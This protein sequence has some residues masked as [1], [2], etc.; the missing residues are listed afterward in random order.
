MATDLSDKSIQSI[1]D[2]EEAREL[3]AQWADEHEE[4]SADERKAH[5]W[6]L[7]VNDE[8]MST[9]DVEELERLCTEEEWDRLDVIMNGEA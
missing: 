8:W 5:L 9:E 6:D 3:D 7:M 4:Q 2:R 1:L